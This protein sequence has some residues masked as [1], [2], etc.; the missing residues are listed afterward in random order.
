[1]LLYTYYILMAWVLVIT[2]IHWWS[3]VCLGNI[4]DKI[5]NE[6]S[7]ELLFLWEGDC[8]LWLGYV[9]KSAL[10]NKLMNRAATPSP[11]WKQAW[12]WSFWGFI[13]QTWCQVI[14]FSQLGWL[15]PQFECFSFEEHPPLEFSK[16]MCPNVHHLVEVLGSSEET[17]GLGHCK[18]WRKITSRW[19]VVV[20]MHWYWDN[21][22]FFS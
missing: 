14:N 13:C 5:C 10:I 6:R 15:S 18:H 16:F 22:E 11:N 17:L 8:I 3:I 20:V 1:M 7:W 2:Y 12:P 9:S 21:E 4:L 19:I